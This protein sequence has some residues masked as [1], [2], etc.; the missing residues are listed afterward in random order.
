MDYFHPT[1]LLKKEPPTRRAAYSDRTAWLMAELSALAYFR[2]EPEGENLIEF[3][4]KLKGLDDDTR[5]RDLLADFI[6][7]Q[8]ALSDDGVTQLESKLDIG[9]F[10][11]VRPFNRGGTQ[12]FLVKR[13]SDKVA[14]LA[15][16]GTEATDIKDIKADL[17]AIITTQGGTRIHTG[18]LK[19]YEQV[20][21]EVEEAVAEVEDYALYV[22]GHSLGGA[23]A[24]IATRELKTPNLAACYTF[25]S[26]RVGNSEFGDSIKT[27][28]YRIVNTADIVPRLP[29]GLAIELLVDFLRLLKNVLPALEY[30][31]KWLDDNVSKYRHHGDMRY[32]TNCKLPDCSDVRLI[33]NITFLARLRRLIKNRLS[34][35]RHISD[36]GIDQYRRKLAAYADK[37][38]RSK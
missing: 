37:R 2:F 23:L 4:S 28:I 29:P 25:G 30:V 19:A 12:A 33:S 6:K 20:R 26:P 18:F 35:N 27:P 31:A 15:F 22:T 32:L 24:L 1:T 36:H 13:E 10:K 14:V 9:E 8:T 38:T 5:I 7:S 34:F 3:A 11:L 17:N 21:T 16:R